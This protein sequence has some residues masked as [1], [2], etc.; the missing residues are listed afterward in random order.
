MIQLSLPFACCSVDLAAYLTRVSGKEV[1]LFL[2]DNRS[3]ILSVR[4]ERE[5]ITVRIHRMFLDAG[6][7]VLR[8]VGEFTRGKRGDLAVIRQYVKAH[9]G[10]LAESARNVRTKERGSYHDLRSIFDSINDE[11]FGGEVTSH[12]TWGPRRLRRIV[13]KRTLGSYRRHTDTIIISTLLDKKQVPPHFV[14]FVVYHEMLHAF[15]GLE[16]K[17][18]RRRVHSAEFRRRERLF[19]EYERAIA[20]ELSH[21][22]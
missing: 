3:S 21:P 19:R 4:P 13:R 9:R 17:E 14:E 11:Y 1:R 12:I 16:E 20:W 22:F 10:R 7:D 15:L 5:H 18:G 8:E 6:M 2:T